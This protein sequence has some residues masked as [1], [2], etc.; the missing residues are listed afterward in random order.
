MVQTLYITS[1]YLNVPQ[2]IQRNTIHW[3]KGASLNI[4]SF[5]DKQLLVLKED[6]GRNWKESKHLKRR[7]L[8]KMYALSNI[9]MEE[10]LRWVSTKA[11]HSNQSV[12][13]R[14]LPAWQVG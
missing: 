5:Y 14:L 4:T 2:C 8:G 3:N 12:K 9:K 10:P 7:V 1:I 6:A 11:N 13:H